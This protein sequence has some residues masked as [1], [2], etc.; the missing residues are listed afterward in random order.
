MDAKVA[1]PHGHF[2][3]QLSL[4]GAQRENGAGFNFGCMQLEF[5]LDT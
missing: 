1:P 2:I 3:A 5:Q 4:Q